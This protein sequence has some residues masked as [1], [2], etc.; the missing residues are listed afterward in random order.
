MSKNISLVDDVLNTQNRN[1]YVQMP[2]FRRAAG[3]IE[4]G[5]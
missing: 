5:E 1:L 3:F 2:G 4:Q